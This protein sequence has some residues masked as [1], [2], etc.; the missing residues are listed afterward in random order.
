MTAPDGELT[1][2]TG[3]RRLGGWLD[4]RV[5]RGVERQ[6]SDFLIRPTEQF[7]GMASE[8]PVSPGAACQVF[9]DG[10]LV[11]TGWIDAYQPEYDKGRHQVMIAGRSLTEDLVDCSLT[12]DEPGF[13]GWSLQAATIGQ[14]AR[15]LCQYFG[16][17]VSLPDG[18]APLDQ[19]YPFV[20][21]PGMTYWQLLEELARSV[22]MLVWDNAAGQLVIS[23]V[24]TVHAGSALVEGENI[25]IGRTW[26]RNDERFSKIRVAGAAM[27]PDGDQEMT[28]QVNWQSV[29]TQIGPPR[30]RPKLIIFDPVGPDNKWA[31]QRANWEIARRIG[32][33][34]MAFVEVTG[35]R[36]G[37]GN[38]WMPNTIVH[39][40]APRL[41]FEDDLVI[42][43]CDW[44]K[45][46]EF[47]TRTM[48]TLMPAAG[49]Q[50][51]P[52]HYVPQIPGAT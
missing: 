32:R 40:S 5:T 28:F 48:L 46:G 10:D 16:V 12:G 34:R 21:D 20:I 50:P 42:T 14:A 30:Y 8:A 38:L 29:D 11:L 9:L 41:K 44:K 24:G 13:T 47:G 1:I 19:K 6:P 51:A 37:A 33:G 39:L 26:I 4:S 36:D 3:G 45:N 2:L 25:E 31:K 27:M 15:N 23:R 22:Q 7:P 17:T 18:D 49:L 43:Q 35:W 52:F